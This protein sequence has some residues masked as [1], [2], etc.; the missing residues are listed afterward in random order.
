MTDSAMCPHCGTMNAQGAERCRLCGR[1]MAHEH[2]RAPGSLLCPH[3]GQ[4]VEEGAEVCS[5]CTM[6][7]REVIMRNLPK[8]LPEN[9]CVHWSENPAAA[10]R[11]SRV[12][13][14]GI[15]V[16]MAGAL[17][18]GQ[19]IA[20]LNPEVA[21]SLM[22]TMEGVLPWV[23]SADDLFV[24]YV[25]LQAWAIAAGLLAVAGGLFALTETRYELAIMG[26]IFG[27]L[28]IGFLMGAF[29]ALVGLLLLAASRKD[30]LPEC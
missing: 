9:E 11:S 13:M 10:G 1:P 22:D 21:G 20:G 26:A 2:A 24:K 12:A 16:M 8:D 4:P 23:S 19:G 6:T 27:V 15:L 30:F 7:V 5:S 29:L 14:A 18:I 17:G 25:A 3:C 28:S